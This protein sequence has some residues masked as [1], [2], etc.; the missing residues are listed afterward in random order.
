[1]QEEE[2]Q[3]AVGI[4]MHMIQ[5]KEFLSIKEVCLLLGV[6][7]MSLHR[8]IKNELIETMKIGSRII[9]KRELINNLIK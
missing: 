7:R 4:D 2:Y 5:S 1:M 3:K 6:S 8:H 9:I